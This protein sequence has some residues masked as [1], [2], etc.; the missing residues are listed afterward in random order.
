M[1]LL[2]IALIAIVVLAMGYFLYGTFIAAQYKL[3]DS[4]DTPAVRKADGVD[5]VPERPFSLMAQHFSAI[6]AAGPIAG[7]ILACVAFGWLPCVLWILIGVV[8]VG[9]VHDF[10][11]LVASIRHGAHS[12]AEIA[13]EN[14]GKRAGV[15]LL[16]FIWI[17][18]LYVI[19]A[20]TQITAETFVGKAEE[21]AGLATSFNKGGAVAMSSVLYLSLALVLGVVQRFLKPPAWLVTIIFIPATLGCVW[22]GTRLDDILNFG[23]ATWVV[24]ILGYCL[25]ASMLPL[26][27]LQ[28]PRGFL[29]G[30]VLYIAIGVGV[31]GILFGGHE[32]KQPAVSEAWR[33]M[34]SPG[35]LLAGA[36]GAPPVTMLLVPFLFV[37]I[38]CGACSGFHGLICGGTTS[39]QISKE[40]HCKPVAFGA[41]LLEGLVAI[42]ALATV[43][44][45]TPAETRGLP[46]AR[47]YGDGLARF[48][49]LL[50]GENAFVFCATFGAMAF[51]TFVFDTLDVSARLGRHLLCELFK[52]SGKWFGLLAA[53]ATVGVPLV[54]LLFGT[55]KAYLAY[56]TLFGTSNQLLAGLTL[57]GVSVWLYRNGRRIW[58][59]VVPMVFVMTITTIALFIQV[60][61]GVRDA[62]RGIWQVDGGRF[63]PVLINACVCVLLLGLAVV[64]VVE[65]CRVVSRHRAAR[66]V[67]A[68]A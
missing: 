55:P 33:N 27:L 51:S 30:V 13:K 23:A 4:V 11:A 65:A 28:Q 9:A 67:A 15:A 49:T 17:A 66:T 22:L 47:I 16:W 64:F 32:V 53:G 59:T 29:G 2:L 25:A 45:L 36:D 14:L 37:T 5:F 54:V 31:V 19:V 41:M 35:P 56:W 63:N 60:W 42:I 6:A 3:D 62:A 40:S 39:R 57:I 58:Y 18:L 46:A 61:A 1:S 50:L 8:F 20:F 43:M 7:P 68:D 24:A 26:W 38:A 10:S 44:M 34:L 12:I 52:V 48:L 21:F